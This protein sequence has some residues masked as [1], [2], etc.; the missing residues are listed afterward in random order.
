MPL[1]FDPITF[2]GQ[3]LYLDRLQ[4]VPQLSSD[5]SFVN[6]IAWA[7]EYGLTWGFEEDLVWIRQQYPEPGLWAPIGNWKQIDWQE[8]FQKI[9][10]KL[11]FVRIPEKLAEEWQGLLGVFNVTEAREHW[12]YLYLVDEL[13]ELKGN[14]FHNKK[15]LFNQFESKYNY[16]YV[17]LDKALIEQALLMQQE[18]CVWRKCEASAGLAAEDRVITKV[19]KSYDLF[20]NMLGGVL[21]VD[22]EIV[23][24]TVGERINQETIVIHFEKAMGGYKGIYQ[25]INQKFLASTQGVTIVNR[26]QD[27]GN[28]GLRKAKMSYNPTAFIKKYGMEWSS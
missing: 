13:V 22:N 14:R 19:L 15:N 17:P 6:L 4:M 28:Q 20:S 8:R 27:L 9:P 3:R 24:F 7:E 21:L 2:A 10:E 18:W 1:H 12:D 25:A 11:P 23:A 5:Y 16:E 26:E